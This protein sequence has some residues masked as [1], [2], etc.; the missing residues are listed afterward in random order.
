MQ[1]A[2][3]YYWIDGGR[4]LGV[5]MCGAGQRGGQRSPA[6]VMAFTKFVAAADNDACDGDG[7]GD[8]DGDPIVASF[9]KFVL[10]FNGLSTVIL[11]TF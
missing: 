6:L 10:H 2:Q 5:A 11:D 1:S 7:D 8:G 3:L 4:V 9:V